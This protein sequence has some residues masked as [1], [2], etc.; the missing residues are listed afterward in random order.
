MTEVTNVSVSTA[1]RG[2]AV[3][4]T[5]SARVAGDLGALQKG[6]KSLAE[7]LGH[8][9][10][11]TGCD[12]LHLG[13]EREFTAGG[14]GGEVA[15]NPQPLPPRELFL[16]GPLPDPWTVTVAIPDKVNRDINALTRATAAVLNKLGCGQCCSGFDIIFRREIALLTVDENLNVRGFGQLA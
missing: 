3:R 12:I 14:L 9:N 5:M 16:T 10:C 15:L 11:A 2:G 7:R 1:V 8:P 6:L 13:M 4:L